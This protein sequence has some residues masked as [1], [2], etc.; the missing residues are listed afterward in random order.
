M[1]PY[2]KSADQ[3]QAEYDAEALVIMEREGRDEVRG[4]WSEYV[5]PARPFRTTGTRLPPGAAWVQPGVFVQH[6]GRRAWVVKTYRT[7][8]TGATLEPGRHSSRE[9]AVAAARSSW[10]SA[11]N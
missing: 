6:V 9:R 7:G 2:G 8:N 4:P 1:G 11:G 5:E 10:I 3:L